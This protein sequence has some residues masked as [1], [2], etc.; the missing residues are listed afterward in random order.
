MV[1]RCY[2]MMLA[3]I[4]GS[5]CRVLLAAQERLRLGGT[6]SKGVPEMPLPYRYRL[7]PQQQIAYEGFDAETLAINLDTGTYYSMPGSSSR[8][9]NLMVTGLPTASIIAEF[10]NAHDGDPDGIS[11]AVREFL[12]RLVAEH[13]I[14]PDETVADDAADGAPA[15]GAARTPFEPFEL[16]VFTDMQDLLLLDPIHDVEDAGWPL[17]KAQ[18]PDKA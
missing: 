17:A 9:W 6:S 12:D 16:N 7:N 3:A 1:G 10:T 14:V 15:Q 18:T 11:K 13:L 2:V 5:N 8:L 4:P